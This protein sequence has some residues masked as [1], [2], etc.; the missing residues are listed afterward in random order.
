MGGAWG[1]QYLK[2]GILKNCRSFE[3]L[4][5]RDMKIRACPLWYPCLPL[6]RLSQ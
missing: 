6:R 3:T 5:L 2:V 4:K 1:V